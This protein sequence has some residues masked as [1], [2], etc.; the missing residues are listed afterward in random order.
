M[1]LNF[2]PIS[3]M[4]TV[5]LHLVQKL[6]NLTTLDLS[7]NNLTVIA[8]DLRN[9]S[10]LF[11]LDLSDNQITGPVPGWISELSLLQYL[12]LSRNLLVDLERSLSLPSL[13]ILDLHRNQLQGSIPV[14]PSSITY[15][16]YSSNNF[17]SLHPP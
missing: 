17:S 14:P 2:H 13:S 6:S 5:E 7:Y 4:G 12:N 8:S 3:S 15:V 1:S 10:K 16:D 11:H 9:Q